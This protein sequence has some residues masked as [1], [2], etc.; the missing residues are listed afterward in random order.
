M[1]RVNDFNKN[2]IPALLCNRATYS[3]ADLCFC[4]PQ[5]RQ[6]YTWSELFQGVRT[7]SES[8][9]KS[10]IKKGDRIAILMENRIELVISMFAAAT[11]G[12]VA[13]PLNTYSKKEEL[14][15]Y[16]LDAKPVILIIGKAGQQLHYPRLINEI[17]AE[18]KNDLITPSWIPPQIFVL[19]EAV[20]AAYPF[21]PFSSLLNDKD[22]MA[23]DA[24][25]DL[26]NATFTTDPAFL[27]YTSGTTGIPKGVARSCASFLVLDNSEGGFSGKIKS[28]L[29][30]MGDRYMRRFSLMN[31]LPL[32]HMGGIGM[33]FTSLKF[34]NFRTVMLTHFNPVNAL[35]AADSEKCNFLVGTPFMLQYMLSSKSAENVQLN[36]VLGVAFT[37]SAVNSQIIERITGE[38]RN[39]YFFT[40]SY[41]SSEAGAVANGSCFFNKNRNMLVSVLLRLLRSTRLLNGEIKY[42]EF[43]RTEH[44]IGGKIDKNVEVAIIDTRTGAFLDIHSEGEIVIRSHRV[45]H[46]IHDNLTKESFL[47]DGWY[48]S[49]DL[50]FIDKN[51]NLLI[52][53]RIKRLI[54]RGGEK[55]SPVEIENVLLRNPAVADVFVLAVPDDLYGEEICAA[56]VEK[57]G[58]ELSVEKL[59]N[60]ISNSLSQFK[61]PKYFVSLPAFPLSPSGKISVPE[62]KR[63]VMEKIKL[64]YA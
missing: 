19:D 25:L 29:S 28:K 47:Q 16:L 33:I 50:G 4:Y 13:I 18:S 58:A 31:L 43:T 27:I 7:L 21:K 51:G 20:D 57:E 9:F 56:F 11:V 63:L 35:K 61:T 34:A 12:A 22:Q 55:I 52:T 37:S 32:Y 62:I 44:S 41:G 38:L 40:V 26:C 8:F 59:R 14:K 30:R 36:S 54:S 5:L 64:N 48:R 10:G 39:L 24:F 23:D 2:T 3:S 46:Y 60:E 1:I 17:V 49:G 45:M 15:T 6:A 42:E 53:N